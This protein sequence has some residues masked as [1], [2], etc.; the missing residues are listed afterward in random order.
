MQE[1]ICKEHALLLPELLNSV[2]FSIHYRF[3]PLSR[4]VLLHLLFEY[5]EM[6]SVEPDPV[7]RMNFLL[8]LY[9]FD[10]KTNNSLNLRKILRSSTGVKYKTS[11][12]FIIVWS[13]FQHSQS[14]DYFESEDYWK[15][16]E[17]AL[18][19]ESLEDWQILK[20]LDH[21]AFLT[22]SMPKLREG[23]E[24]AGLSFRKWIFSIRIAKIFR[25]LSIDPSALKGF[26]ASIEIPFI[27]TIECLGLLSSFTQA[28]LEISSDNF[29]DS[30][31]RFAESTF[32]QF[33]LVLSSK[34][35][36][37]VNFPLGAQNHRKIRRQ[38]I[39]EFAFD[40]AI[41]VEEM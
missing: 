33:L 7:I 9:K 38:A 36:L 1:C 26:V 34:V 19:R 11:P 17:S 35:S 41:N 13:S 6:I 24:C 8:Q 37:Y 40:H 23:A 27:D 25:K 30:D 29:Y 3:R 12:P 20:S 22:T 39:S 32:S 31:L 28:A 21:I 18:E 14:K 2:N 5:L 4:K 15:V 16:I 10:F